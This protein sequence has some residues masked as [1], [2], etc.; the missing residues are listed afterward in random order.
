MNEVE[1][2]LFPIPGSVSLPFSRVPL[3][4]FEPRYR[5]MIK[6]SV[7]AKRRIGVAHT[8]RLIA[9]S[10]VPVNATRD[11][12]L[13]NNQETYEAH[14][15]FSAGF[16]EILETLPDGRILVQIEMDSRFE[17]LSELQQIPYKVVRCRPYEDEMGVD[18]TTERF[19]QELDRVLL[20]LPTPNRE[21]LDQYLESPEWKSMGT[22][23]YSF[24]VY[25]LILFDPDILQRVLETKSALARI[26][27]LKDA[28]G[29]R[30]LQ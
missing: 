19:R 22:I 3:H 24:A 26:S 16:A 17:I 15:I 14:S 27:F 29:V 7:A 11:E 18:D 23:Q 30:V 8:K 1:I 9:E 4:I 28:L 20:N 21:A 25:Q 10:K 6:D 2:S 5:K 13:N 12:V